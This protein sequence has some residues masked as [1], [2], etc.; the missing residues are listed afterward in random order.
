MDKLTTQI[1]LLNQI[2]KDMRYNLETLKKMFKNE[3]GIKQKIVLVEALTNQIYM[4]IME[5]IETKEINEQFFNIIKDIRKEK[6][7]E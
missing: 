4:S 5:K 2:Y 6:N 3:S 1:K 7:N